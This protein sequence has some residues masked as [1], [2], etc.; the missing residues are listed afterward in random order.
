MYLFT[1]LV[2]QKQPWHDISVDG[3][4]ITVW[5]RCPIAAPHSKRRISGCPRS[6]SSVAAPSRNFSSQA[7]NQTAN[8]QFRCTC[9]ILGRYKAYVI[10]DFRCRLFG[11]WGCF[12][13]GNPQRWLRVDSKLWNPGCGVQCLYYCV[14][15]KIGI[16]RYWLHKVDRTES[17][18]YNGLHSVESNVFTLQYWN[19]DVFSMILATY[20]GLQGVDSMGLTLRYGVLFVN[21]SVRTGIN[22]TVWTPQCGLV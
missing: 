22:F 18:T 13:L 1:I 9:R 21:S 7:V 11:R 4:G 15:F 5:V 19:K 8:V 17:T 3:E 14:D 20:S 16:P 10:A 6:R 12:P 2:S